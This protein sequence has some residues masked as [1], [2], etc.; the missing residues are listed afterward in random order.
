MLLLGFF[1]RLIFVPAEGFKSDVGTFESWALTLAQHP[2]DQ[3]FSSAGFADYP[4]GYFFVLWIVGHAYEWFTRGADNYDLLKLFVKMPA[5]VMDLVSA[6]LIFTIVRRYASLAWA[7]AAAA[8]FAFNPAAIFI[9][10][11]WGQVDSVAGGVTL[12]SLLLMIDADRRTGRARTLSIAG[13]WLLLAYSIL[14]KPPAI[15][16]VPLYLAYVFATPPCAGLARSRPESGSPGRSC[17][18]TSPRPSSIM[19]RIRLRSLRGSWGATPM[20]RACISTIPS[21]PSTSTSWPSTTSG[22]PTAC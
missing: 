7:F 18:P 2:L 19:R 11:D 12:G 17:W 14:I 20:R 3:F 21:T 4:P 9:S 13:A 6:W 16:L 1:V 5:I 15:V 8:L 22:S 10:A